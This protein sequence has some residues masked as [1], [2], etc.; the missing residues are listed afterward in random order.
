M[1][2][3][4]DVLVVI[5]F[6]RF[7]LGDLKRSNKTTGKRLLYSTVVNKTP[8]TLRLVD[9]VKVVVQLQKRLTIR[10]LPE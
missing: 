4:I 6:S 8:I 5:L 3:H 9:K 1:R 2:V 7:I 10:E